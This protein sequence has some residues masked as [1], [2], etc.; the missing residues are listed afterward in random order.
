M[1]SSDTSA[2]P[3]DINKSWFP[4]I[5]RLQSIAKSGGLSVVSISIIVDAD[6]TPKA[7]TSPRKTLIEPKSAAG[8]I[9]ALFINQE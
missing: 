5:R 9:L 1:V 8:A 7:W 4:V 6:G 2:I 3:L